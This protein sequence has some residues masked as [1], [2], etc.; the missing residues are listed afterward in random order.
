MVELILLP[1]IARAALVQRER[2]RETER[3]IAVDVPVF[4]VRLLCITDTRSKPGV[5]GLRHCST[6]RFTLVSGRY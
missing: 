2:D 5:S 4:I 1:I 3:G 6:C